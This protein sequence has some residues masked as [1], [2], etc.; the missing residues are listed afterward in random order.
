MNAERLVEKV[1][2]TVNYPKLGEDEALAYLNDG[3]KIIA[4]RV[5]LPGLSNG[6]ATMHTAIDAYSIDLPADYHRNLYL[7][8]IERRD[9]PIMLDMRS[10]SSSTGPIA[11]NN[12]PPELLA[13]AAQAGKFIY[14]N[15]PETS[16]EVAMLRS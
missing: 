12:T 11:V 9:L 2:N 1:L 5:L 16:V 13:V 15:V 4:S 10:L 8:Q 3:Q 6:A 7:A 14:Q